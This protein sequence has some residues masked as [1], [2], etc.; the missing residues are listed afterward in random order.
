[1]FSKDTLLI[2]ATLQDFIDAAREAFRPEEYIQTEVLKNIAGTLQDLASELGCSTGTIT[3][4]K[5]Q[6]YLELATIELSE[7][8]TL[9][10]IR[11][12]RE[13]YM[14]YKQAH[15]NNK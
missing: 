8:C 5:A 7:R 1:M 15:R 6:G 3:K 14:A 13:A 12:A 9:Y 2:Q 11:K 4:M 10:D